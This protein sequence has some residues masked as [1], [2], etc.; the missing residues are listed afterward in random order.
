MESFCWLILVYFLYGELVLFLFKIIVALRERENNIY[1]LVVSTISEGGQ[2]HL[3]PAA[4][5]FTPTL[6]FELR[7]A[8]FLLK[9]TFILSS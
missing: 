9:P 1:N 7:S 5:L 8:S 6:H 3:N 2:I 4:I